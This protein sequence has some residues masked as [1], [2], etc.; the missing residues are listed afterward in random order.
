MTHYTVD[1]NALPEGEKRIAK[2]LKDCKDWLGTRQ[3]REIIQIIRTDRGRTSRNMLLLG[4]SL[5]GIQGYPAEVMIDEFWS[6]QRDLFDK[7]WAR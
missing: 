4:L 7:K 5:R 2:A 1:Y 3:Y 6:P